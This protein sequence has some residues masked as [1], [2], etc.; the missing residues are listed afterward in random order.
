M[1]RLNYYNF[2]KNKPQNAEDRLTRAFL[3]LVRLIPSVQA[4]FIEVVREKQRAQGDGAL[5]PARTTTDTGVTGLWSQTGTLHADEGRVLSILLTNHPWETPEPRPA[6][7]AQGGVRRRYALRR[8]VGICRR[9][10][11]LWKRT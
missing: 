5:V 6:Q 10:Q 4:A 11:A 2:F 8:R 1:S 3:V 9:E 7:H